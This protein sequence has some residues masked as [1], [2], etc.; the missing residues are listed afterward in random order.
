MRAWSPAVDVAR[1]QRRS[2]TVLSRP[3]TNRMRR[4]AHRGTFPRTPH[5][6]SRAKATPV[7]TT[8]PGSLNSRARPR[9]PGL[10]SPVGVEPA[11]TEGPSPSTHSLCLRHWSDAWAG[12]TGTFRRAMSSMAR[13]AR[14]APSAVEAG[15][16]ACDLGQQVAQFGR[17][18]HLESAAETGDLAGERANAL[19]PELD[20]D[21]SV[22][23]GRPDLHPV[24]E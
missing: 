4:S 16:L 19:P 15:E 7:P 2:I 12:G 5:Q 21:P 11:R 9:G 22:G 8:S 10:S 14:R 17:L 13:G 6:W 23:T 20:L 1:P 3:E 24:A 18:E